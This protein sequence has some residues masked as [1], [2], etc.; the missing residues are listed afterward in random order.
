M[1]EK[2]ESSCSS[3]EQLHMPIDQLLTFLEKKFLPLI[4]PEDNDFD[5]D[6][7]VIRRL[8][9]FRLKNKDNEELIKR[10]N[11]FVGPIDLDDPD[12][13]EDYGSDSDEEDSDDD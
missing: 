11:V 9:Q 13:N 2:K 1:S 7:L 10:I 4:D 12:D 6:S 8:K 3:Y 5:I